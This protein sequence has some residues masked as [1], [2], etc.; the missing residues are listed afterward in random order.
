MVVLTKLTFAACALSCHC[1]RWTL[2]IL[3]LFIFKLPVITP[4]PSLFKELLVFVSK[5]LLL[6]PSVALVGSAT[7]MSLLPFISGPFVTSKVNILLSTYFLLTTSLSLSSPLSLCCH[8]LVLIMCFSIFVVI[9]YRYLFS[10]LWCL[11]HHIVL[12]LGHKWSYHQHPICYH[13]PIL[14]TGYH[15]F[16]SVCCLLKCLINSIIIGTGVSAFLV[17]DYQ[18]HHHL[19]NLQIH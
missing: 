12:F 7:L 8:N 13:F 10:Y 14:T 3:L 4:V 19:E 15:H 16:F 18:S 2:I 11:C 17:D 6:L 9:S 1:A 5:Y